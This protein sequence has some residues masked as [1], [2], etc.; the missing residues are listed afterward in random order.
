MTI[1][2]IKK[3]EKPK[4]KTCVM[5]CDNKLHS[6]LDKYELTKFM[7]QHSTNLL[8]GKPRSGKTSLLYSLFQSNKMLKKVFHNI[9]LFQP[10]HSRSSM[11]DKLFDVLDDNNKIEELTYE[12]LLEVK[13]RIQEANEEEN[14]CIIFD[15]MTAY[16]K[17]NDV[18]KLLKEL[19]YNRRH[20]H[21]SIFFLCQTWYSVPKDIRKLFSNIFIFKVSKNELKSIFEEVVEDQ[22]KLNNIDG[23]RKIVYDKNFEYLFI[24]T[25]SGR[26]FK[27]FDELIFE[28]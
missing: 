17:D 7:N 8:I 22:E 5:N 3:N 26:M 23:I 15:D 16:L 20:L 27:G 10:S 14:N 28:E 4:L 18:S 25:D 21:V 9:Y 12:S 11:K 13:E 24:N 6:K 1:I 19:V 2:T